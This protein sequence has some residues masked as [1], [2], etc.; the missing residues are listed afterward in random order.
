MTV[1]VATYHTVRYGA[2]WLV[3]SKY[4]NDGDTDSADPRA[5]HETLET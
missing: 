4:I 5:F 1:K 3:I 2:E